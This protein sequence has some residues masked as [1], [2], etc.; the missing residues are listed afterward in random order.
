MVMIREERHV[1]MPPPAYHPQTSSITVS[2]C[3]GGVLRNL[4]V[5]AS[6][7]GKWQNFDYVN[8][9]HMSMATLDLLAE[10]CGIT[11]EGKMYYIIKNHGFKLLLGYDDILQNASEHMCN[12]EFCVY[13]EYNPPHPE[14]E[15]L[16]TPEPVG[17]VNPDILPPQ[18]P[19]VLVQEDANQGIARTVLTE[20]GPA[21]TQASQPGPS[22]YEQLQMANNSTSLQPQFTLQPRLNI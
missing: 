5:P 13:I 7:G 19:Q 16:T 14:E 10:K 9:N 8:V 12:R 3:Y 21:I 15:S 18:N 6:V 17:S 1:K 2:V 4:P 22:M 20:P 11:E